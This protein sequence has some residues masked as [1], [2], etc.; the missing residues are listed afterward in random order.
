MKPRQLLLFL[1]FDGVLN[2]DT[3]RMY[4]G[5]NVE[6][7][8]ALDDSA[9]ARLAMLL[10]AAPIEVVI[11]SCWRIGWSLGQLVET[12]VNHGLPARLAGRFVGMTPRG[13]PRFE[14]IHEITAW[15]EANR[16]D[17]VQPT[18]FDVDPSVRWCA[19]DDNGI[20]VDDPRLVRTDHE[21]GLEEVH[22]WR[23]LRV[24]G[25]EP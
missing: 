7:L 9:V 4:A 6:G 25:V 14:R 8:D 1:D 11:S 12:L 16:P 13:L 5:R 15:L 18:A 20:G 24:L 23:V 21:W 22:I 3:W 2:S 19:L 10:E 17:G